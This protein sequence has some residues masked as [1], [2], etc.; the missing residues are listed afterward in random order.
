[1][2]LAAKIQTPNNRVNSGQCTIF[3]IFVDLSALTLP[4]QIPDEEG[5]LTQNF[6]FTLLC[7]A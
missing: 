1:M 3:E 2:L 5:K 4:I 6:I 7:G